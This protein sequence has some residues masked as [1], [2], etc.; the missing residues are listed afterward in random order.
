M[1]IHAVYKEFKY[2][3]F[4][5][6]TTNKIASSRIYTACVDNADRQYLY[7]R[8]KKYLQE[9]EETAIHRVEA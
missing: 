1:I 5:K 6:W 8:C 3:I 9:G 2:Y 7:N 4:Y